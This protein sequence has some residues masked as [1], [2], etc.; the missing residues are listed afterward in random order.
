VVTN[1]IIPSLTSTPYD[2]LVYTPTNTIYISDP[3]TPSGTNF[4]LVE[5]CGNV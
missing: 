4:K 5:I 3:D 2:V 1:T